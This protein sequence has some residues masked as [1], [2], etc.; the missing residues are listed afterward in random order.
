MPAPGRVAHGIRSDVIRQRLFARKNHKLQ[1][2]LSV[3]PASSRNPSGARLRGEKSL[4]QP[5]DLGW[6]DSGSRPE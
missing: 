4:F 3:I 2:K 5:K 1:K 6:L